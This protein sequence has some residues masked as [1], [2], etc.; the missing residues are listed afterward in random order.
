VTTRPN[1]DAVCETILEHVERI[2]AV[3]C[4]EFVV[5]VIDGRLCKIT[6]DCAMRLAWDLCSKLDK[7]RDAAAV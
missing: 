3:C 7:V 5:L 4:S 2:D 6:H 1:T